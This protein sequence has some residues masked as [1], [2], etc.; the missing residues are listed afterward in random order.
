MLYDISLKIAYR[1]HPAAAGSRRLLRIS[2]RTIAGVQAVHGLSLSIDPLPAEQTGFDDF[3][4][5]AVTSLSHARTHDTLDVTMT[6]R[7]EVDRADPALD[8]SPDPAGLAAEIAGNADLSPRSP[9][10]YLSSGPFAIIA[11]PLTDFARK[12]VQPGASVRAIAEDMARRIPQELR[13]D[14]TATDVTTT[15]PE[16]FDLQGGVCQDFSHIMIAGLRGLGIPAAYV[17]GCLRTEPPPGRDRLQ[18]SDAMHA[19]VSV[20]CGLEAGWQDF[21]PTNGIPAGDDHITIAHGRD[22]ADVPP[23]VGILKTAGDQEA[24]HS[25]DVVPVG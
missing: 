10:H 14:G 12:S 7:V 15:A 21:D 9:H 4:G 25:V 11:D 8:V 20:W 2:P 6:A 22:Y 18:G 1:Y 5:N 23:I 17:S 24:S 19:W 16:A 13:Y 3:F